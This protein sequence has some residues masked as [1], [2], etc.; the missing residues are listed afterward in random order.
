MSVF[1][2]EVVSAGR[3]IA[4]ANTM[5]LSEDPRPVIL[6]PGRMV[7]G[8]GRH[9]LIEAASMLKAIR[10]TDDFSCVIIG[11]GDATHRDELEKAIRAANVGDVVRIGGPVTDMPAAM[12][13]ASIVAVPST[14]PET[15]AR[16]LIEAQAMGRPVVAS[17][18]G[19]APDVM[20]GGSS[21]WLVPPA[22]AAA[23]AGALSEALDMDSSAR[24]HI[25]MAG[26]ALVRSRFTLGA[27]LEATMAVHARAAGRA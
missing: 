20:Q 2:E 6:S 12:K 27:M 23:L 26:R 8:K 17:N 11:D 22:D 15:S 7:P 25:G 16:V 14:K 19:A 4:L 10:G 3:A 1:A 24:A 21:G 13:L 9:V 18:H 5:G